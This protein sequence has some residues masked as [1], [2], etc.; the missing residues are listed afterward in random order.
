MLVCFRHGHVGR[1]SPALHFEQLPI[2]S[3][4]ASF[5]RLTGWEAVSWEV[6]I[7]KPTFPDTRRTRQVWV[8]CF[9]TSLWWFEDFRCQIHFQND[10][11]NWWYSFN[12]MT[13]WKTLLCFFFVSS[14][15]SLA[16]LMSLAIPDFRMKHHVVLQ[17]PSRNV[18]QEILAAD[19]IMSPKTLLNQSVVPQGV[20]GFRFPGWKDELGLQMWTR[21]VTGNVNLDC[22]K[23]VQMI[24]CVVSFSKIL[25]WT[26]G[27]LCLERFWYFFLANAAEKRKH[28]TAYQAHQQTLQM[29]KKRPC[30]PCQAWKCNSKVLNTR[31]T[32]WHVWFTYIHIGIHEAFWGICWHHW[33]FDFQDQV[34]IFIAK[35]RAAAR[36]NGIFLFQVRPADLRAPRAR[37][38]EVS[39]FFIL[40]P[41]MPDQVQVQTINHQVPMKSTQWWKCD[42]TTR[43]RWLRK[44]LW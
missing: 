31:E 23:N 7:Q 2:F 18:L 4:V 21:I 40:N 36:G 1:S 19:I 22:R 43:K 37:L 9:G 28:Q 6:Q 39:L 34:L 3:T 5:K 10:L 29:K 15:W 32:S 25:S 14:L 38:K 41:E 42:G 44:E 30:H 20:V 24:W 13:D 33:N 12:N 11:Q 17:L 8:T 27:L 16:L 26:G 35:P